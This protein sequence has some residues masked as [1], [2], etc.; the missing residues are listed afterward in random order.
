M[1]RFLIAAI[2]ALACQTLSPVHAQEREGGEG[3]RKVWFAAGDRV[4]VVAAGPGFRIGTE[5]QALT[6][7][8]DGQSVRVRTE[9]G[10][11]LTGT[12]VG[13]R[14]VEVAL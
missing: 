9:G 1:P 3:G 4:K 11:V 13:E 6:R 2:A 14:E 12:A 8:L 10:R 7:G 5:G